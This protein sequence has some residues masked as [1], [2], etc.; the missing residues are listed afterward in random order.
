[1]EATN[2]SATVQAI[3]ATV[4]QITTALASGVDDVS[5]SW[6]KSNTDA[7]LGWPPFAGTLLELTAGRGDGDAGYA[8]RGMDG[9][10][11]ERTS[12]GLRFDTE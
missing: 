8:G 1:V 9:S 11:L 7:A 5:S 3:S 2:A 12:Y 4:E 6:E 10:Q